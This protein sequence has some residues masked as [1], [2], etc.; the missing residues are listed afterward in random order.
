[1]AEYKVILSD[2]A[3]QFLNLYLTVCLLRPE[4]TRNDYPNLVVNNFINSLMNRRLDFMAMYE[5]KFGK[6]YIE[7]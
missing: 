6:P 1:M 5:K 3:E 2:E 4:H 7:E